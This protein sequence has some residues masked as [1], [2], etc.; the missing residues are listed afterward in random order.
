MEGGGLGRRLDLALE[1]LE[2]EADGD[3]VV[4]WGV[5]RELGVRVDV[6]AEEGVGE[7]GARLRVLVLEGGEDV[8]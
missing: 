8:T 1:S 5:V 6:E 4:V 3:G 2:G 7:G